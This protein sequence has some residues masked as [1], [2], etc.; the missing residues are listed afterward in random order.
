[1]SAIMQPLE[2]STVVSYPLPSCYRVTHLY[3]VRVNATDVPVNDT[4]PIFENYNYCHFSFSG[5]IMITITA[6]EEIA[7]YN[8]SP[9][10]LGIIGTVAG[11]KLTF[12]LASSQYLIVKINGLKELVIVADELESNIPP[13]SGTGI[14]NVKDLPYNADGTGMN[15]ATNAIQAAID[16]ANTGGGGI[17]YIPSGVYK[18]GNI[19]LKSNVSMYLEGGAVILGS[20][21]PKDYTTHYRKNSLDMGGTWFIYTEMGATNIMIFGRGTI[22]GNGHYM[23]NMN[24]YLNNLIVPL[25][26]SYF[27]MDGV[28]LRDSGLWSLIPTRSRNITIQNVK[29]FNNNGIDHEADAIDI[30]ECQNVQVVHVIA[31]AEDDTFCTKTWDEDTD[32]AANWPGCP[33]PLTDVMFD[34]C[35]AWSRCATYKVGFGNCQKQS[36]ITFKNSTS[37]QSMRAMT[38]NHRWGAPVTENVTF[39]NIDV[40]DFWPREGNSSRWLE[41]TADSGPIKN[42]IIRNIKLR[43]VGDTTSRI[44]GKS[45]SVQVK[46]V[47]ISS[48]SVNGEYA[49]SLEAMNVTDINNY[50]DDI[51]LTK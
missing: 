17:V 48:V 12:T 23:R 24:H 46:G 43:K 16:D 51:I 28:T 3:S 11:N 18:C 14:Y 45:T 21:D 4:V 42:T 2:I 44:T 27:T 38:I 40:E 26:C 33:E 6:C 13:S 29:L 5:T 34:E 1:M 20:G 39:E 10:K 8:I 32:I 50:I 47:V 35:V 37:Y 9:L 22:D 25:K 36:N 49:N 31:V 7:S 30:Q 19:V 15:M 41:I